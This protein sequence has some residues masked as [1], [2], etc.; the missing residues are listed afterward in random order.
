MRSSFK[1][2]TAFLAM[3]FLAGCNTYLDELWKTNVKFEES[4]V[5]NVSR[6]AELE[7]VCAELNDNIDALAALVDVVANSDFIT[8]IVPLLEEGVERGY[9]ISFAKAPQVTI[10]NGKDGLEAVIPKVGVKL[11]ETD[12]SYYW[13][14][15]GEWIIVD[16]QRIRCVGTD[17]KEPLLGIENGEWRISYD[18]GQTWENLGPADG[19]DADTMFSSIIENEKS[20]VF[21]FSDGS[22]FSVPKSPVISITF[23]IEGDEA[24]IEARQEITIRY[25]LENATE[26]T[27]V[28]AMSDGHYRVS[29]RQESISEGYLKISGPD[30]YRDGYVTVLVH[31]GDCFSFTRI[32]KFYKREINFVDGNE[33]VISPRGGIQPIPV[34]LNFSYTVQVEDGSWVNILPESKAD[35]SVSVINCQ[36]MP[37]Y[38]YSERRTKLF[39]IADNAPDIP[40][41]EI[42][43]IQGA[44]YFSM[45]RNRFVLKSGASSFETMIQ[46]SMDLTVSAEDEWLEVNV[47]KISDDNYLLT[48][49]ADFNSGEK[50]S[51]TISLKH[52]LDSSEL[53]SIE[54]LQLDEDSE[55]PEDM[56]F[57]VRASYS[58]SFKAYLPLAGEMDCYV[59]WGDGTEPE[60]FTQY[61]VSHTYAA[62]TPE[63]YTVR[64]SGRV[65]A[66]NS[67]GLPSPC[68]KEVVQWGN[69]GLTS[70]AGAFENS[71]ILEKLPN[72]DNNA[73]VDVV[74]F[75]SAFKNCIALKALPDNLFTKCDK[76]RSFSNT[77]ENC[78]SL[79]SLPDNMFRYC[80]SAEAFDYTF[81]RCGALKELPVDLFAHNT[82]VI[83]FT[84]TFSDCG[85]TE[86]PESLLDSCTEL[87]DVNSMFNG[88]P[89]TGIPEDLF[90]NCT[91]ITDFSAT[92][93]NTDITE[94]PEILF[95]D[96]RN[97]KT[98][99]S[100]FSYCDKLA[101]VPVSMFDNNRRVIDFG[102]LFAGCDNVSGE[103]PYTEVNGEKI[104]L[105]ERK[106]Y[107]DYFSD[108]RTYKACFADCSKLDDFESIPENWKW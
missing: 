5:E 100:T 57:K 59:D 91:E 17:R 40:H 81:R 90:R 45:E 14:I 25:R 49:A 60:H 50:R 1:I 54:V 44:A 66:L 56:I 16:G 12:Q 84:A 24:G 103:S 71:D 37:N 47:R 41:A 4:I 9:V 95:N 51:T 32:I 20:V 77:F 108:V 26:N 106:G 27:I 30:P 31:D 48:A 96:C 23:D 74:S 22:I 21:T 34:E 58:N 68:V 93:S 52:F 19:E 55:S 89:L 67:S 104:H 80:V 72:D 11:D 70:M 107:P 88:C 98:F 3:M 53:G 101:N 105:Y 7:K 69:T 63:D 8:S 46:S 18:E 10:Y 35:M 97:A 65:T 2:M 43:L 39:I 79:E 102:N 62:N 92:F 87:K 94:V 36:V 38:E 61:P 13:T 73:F 76:V 42:T 33:F 85:L 82:K 6:I 29:V 99:N 83:R 28:T 75:E 15:D 64:I 78:I 86:I